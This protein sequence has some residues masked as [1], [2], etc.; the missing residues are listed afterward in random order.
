[1]TTTSTSDGYLYSETGLKAGLPSESVIS[2]PQKIDRQVDIW[3]VAVIGAGYAGLVAAR[4][5]TLRGCRVLLVEARDR[6]GG[7]T[8]TSTIDGY[9]YEMGGTWIHWCQP[10]LFHELSRY[11]LTKEIMFSQQYSDNDRVMTAKVLSIYCDI[12]GCQARRVIPLPYDPASRGEVAERWDAYSA[13]DRLNQVRS[14]LSTE[15]IALLQA[16]I[17]RTGG[18]ADLEKIAFWDILRW[19]A[20]C[21]YDGNGL[22]GSTALCRLKCGQTALAQSIFREALDTGYLSYM[23]QDPVVRVDQTDKSG[24]TVHCLSAEVFRA[25]R[26]VCTIPLN[27][28]SDILFRPSLS[29]SKIRALTSGSIALASKVNFEVTGSGLRQWSGIA[30]PACGGISYACADGTTPSGTTHI[31][32]NIFPICPEKD[33]ETIKDALLRIKPLGI[34]KIVFHNWATDVYA[35]G[36][37]TT[38]KPNMSRE[39]LGPLQERHGWLFFANSDWADGWRGFIDGAIEQGMKV[40]KQV[41]TE[42][43]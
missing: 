39:S 31:A 7:R 13:S 4:D 3:D 20:L 15:E 25:K 21:G 34:K 10:H 29:G 24:A 23:F 12:D 11:G 5:L 27:V 19:W 38:F 1:M 17:M 37:W 35:K 36:A 16:I 42:L 30:H 33:I 2:P 28:L 40:A 8:W 41:A 22:A 6:I 32:A 14:Q 18:S 43:I 9:Q 26:I